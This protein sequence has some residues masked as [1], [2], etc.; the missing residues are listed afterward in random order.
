MN[1]FIGK[2]FDTWLRSDPA[3]LDN[4]KFALEEDGPWKSLK[5]IFAIKVSQTSV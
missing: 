5:E 2:M 4:Y 3:L 1:G